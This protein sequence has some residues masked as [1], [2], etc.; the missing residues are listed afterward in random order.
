MFHNGLAVFN[1]SMPARS[2]PPELGTC[3]QTVLILYLLVFYKHLR[4][5][6]LRQ[7]SWP[8][9][10][11][12]AEFIANRLAAAGWSRQTTLGR[13]SSVS[14]ETGFS[15]GFNPLNRPASQGVGSLLQVPE[16]LVVLEAALQPTAEV[17][18]APSAKS[19]NDDA[20]LMATVGKGIGGS[21]RMVAVEL[22]AY[23]AVCL[24]CFQT[25]REDIW[26]HAWQTFLKVLKPHG[27][28]EKVTDYQQRPARAHDIERPRHRT[29][30]I[31]AVLYHFGLN[32]L[33]CCK[34]SRQNVP[35]QDIVNI[36]SI[37]TPFA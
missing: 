9:A 20:E 28:G 21:R 14:L 29:R 34:R 19:Q 23:Q 8:A 32:H 22:A 7:Q 15:T 30:R 6:L 3:A 33:V 4:G 13:L 10:D 12:S 36:I 25:I 26:R 16:T 11:R 37:G 24:K 27:A 18:G 31:K 2:Y 17:S 35:C 5:G 1:G